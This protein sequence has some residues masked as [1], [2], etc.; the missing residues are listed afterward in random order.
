V[1]RGEVWW[2][3]LGR[4]RASEPGYRRPVVIV[5]SN[6]FNRSS[7][8]TVIVVVMTT[9][10]NLAMAPGNLV[11]RP[12]ASGLPRPSVINVSQVATLDR[13]QL[14]ERVGR[15]PEGTMHSLDEGLRLV[16]AL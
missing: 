5:Q 12:R 10:L 13:T 6:D 7:L 14:L 3:S 15:L 11:C 8:S 1:E 9:N 2:A 16:L 4:P